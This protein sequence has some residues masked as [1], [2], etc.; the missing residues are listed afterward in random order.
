MHNKYV[1]LFA[2]FFNFSCILLNLENFDVILN[3]Y[4]NDYL[5]DLNY[6][7]YQNIASMISPFSITLVNYVIS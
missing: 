5:G 2:H 3:A 7:I 4:E 1:D 6:A